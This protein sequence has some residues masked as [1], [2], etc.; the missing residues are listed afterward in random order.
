MTL[1]SGLG[2]NGPRFGAKWGRVGFTPYR[3]E[4]R[5]P[6]FRGQFSHTLDKKGRVSIPVRFREIL[7]AQYDDQ[8]VLSPREGGC[9]RAYPLLEWE[10]LEENLKRFNKFNRTVD[11]FKRMLF[12]SAQDCSMD[13]QGRI[14]VHPEL[15]ERAGLGEKVLFV[16]MME[17]F[18]IWNRE[19]FLEKFTPRGDMIPD[20]EDELARLAE[21]QGI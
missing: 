10:R 8:L 19:D 15:R 5:M 18:E 1:K 2:F 9:I 13:A 11:N 21:K 7:R 4:R 16:G 20:I 3:T 14:L 17:F 12:S 6:S